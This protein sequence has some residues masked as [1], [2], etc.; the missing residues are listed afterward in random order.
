[1]RHIVTAKLR[2]LRG[3]DSPAGCIAGSSAA[4]PR[5]GQ[6]GGCIAGSGA[7]G[8]PSPD[9]PGPPIVAFG[10]AGAPTDPPGARAVPR[11]RRLADDHAEN[12]KDGTHVRRLLFVAALTLASAPP[13]AAQAPEPIAYTLRFPAPHTHYVAVDALVPTGGRP[14]V[15]LMMAVWTPGSYLVR[16][17]ARTSRGSPPA[18]G[19][20]PAADREVAQE[21]LA[22][23][24][25]GGGRH[26]G[27]LPGLRARDVG[28]HE[29]DRGRLRDAERRADVPH[30]GRRRRRP[31]P[32]RVPG[33]PGN[34]GR[35]RDGAAAASRRRPPRLARPRLR[36]A[37]RLADRGRQSDRPSVHRRRGA[38]RARQ[39][40][41]I[42]GLDGPRSADDTER[43]TRELHRMW[44]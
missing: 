4:A 38:P 10:P 42:G 15:E 12:G 20:R 37:G 25:R 28:A 36:H 23:G 44:A 32:R 6:F 13:A 41:R 3:T 40:R 35:H 16:E 18:P 30:P 11:R 43:I 34:L 33:A 7:A 22:G 27:V 17:Y 2:Q 14:A 21:P 19:R 5:N 1:M 8:L 29:L 24:H 39:R 26:R 9:A 31:T